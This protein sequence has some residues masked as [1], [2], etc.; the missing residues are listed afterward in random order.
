VVEA[1]DTAAKV[2]VSGTTAKVTFR[3]RP[4]NKLKFK[5]KL[6]KGKFKPCT[7]PKRYRHLSAGKHKVQVEAIS[8]TGTV[9]PTPANKTFTV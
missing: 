9:D 5:C 8:K 7:S 1:P 3:G 4:G 6:D 2:Q